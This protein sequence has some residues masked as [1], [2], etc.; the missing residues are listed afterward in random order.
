MSGRRRFPRTGPSSVGRSFARNEPFHVA[1][2][3]TATE[4]RVTAEGVS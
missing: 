3:R 2:M 1:F 4:A